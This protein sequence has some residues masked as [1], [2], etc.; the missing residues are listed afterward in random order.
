[1]MMMPLSEEQCACAFNAFFSTTFFKEDNS[2]VPIVTDFDYPFME[3]IDITAEGIASLINNLK[4]S[5]SGGIDNINTKILKNTVGTS[6]QILFHIFQQSLTSGQLPKDWKIAKVIPVFK[7]GN[8]T[9]RENYR[10]ISLT[11][12]CC[13]L[14]EHI[15]ASHIFRHLEKNKHFHNNQHGFR[16]GLSCDTQLLE[17]NT[18][19]HF[20]LNSNQQ[21]DC[22]VLDFSK[23]F[24]RVA[25]C[26]LISKLSPL[27]IDSLTLFWLRNFLSLRQQFTIV[28]DFA[29][30]ITDVT[31]GVLQGSVLGPLLFLVYIND[32]PNNIS[33]CVRLFADDCIIYGIITVHEITANYREILILLIPGATHGK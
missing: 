16:K 5:T 32:L 23:A 29:S 2:N 19:L 13:K 28:N 3:E 14:L 7:N 20:N 33:S 27:N 31:F 17:F 30:L 25:H 1:M 26:H 6:S 12:I 15:I 8:K 11:C 24:D 10:P 18:D 4:I 22:I 9:S 21:T